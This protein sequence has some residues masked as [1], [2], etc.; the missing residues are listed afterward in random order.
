MNVSLNTPSCVLLILLVHPR[1]LSISFTLV[2]GP[3]RFVLSCKNLKLIYVIS[4]SGQD[5]MR[6]AEKAGEER[7]FKSH[8]V[9]SSL[10][11]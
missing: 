8:Q 11:F 5:K 2:N 3:I 9:I 6:C 4:F 7:S 1:G 10:D